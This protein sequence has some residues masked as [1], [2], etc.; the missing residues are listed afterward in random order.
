M[1]TNAF[2][3]LSMLSKLRTLEITEDADLTPVLKS[4]KSLPK[5]NSL[6]LRS[7]ISLDGVKMLPTLPNL[8]TLDLYRVA[9]TNS[10]TAHETLS[11][12]STVPKLQILTITRLPIG[13]DSVP[14]LKSFKNLKLFSTDESFVRPDVRSTLMKNL[15]KLDIYWRGHTQRANYEML[16]VRSR[17]QSIR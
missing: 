17:L 8:R 5:I 14:V 3:K 11:I 13:L 6:V 12:L 7:D 2:S 9:P 16:R 10:A 15:P 4:I 1:D